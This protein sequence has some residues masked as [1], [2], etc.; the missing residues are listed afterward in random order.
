MAT[1]QKRQTKDGTRYRVQVRLRGHPPVS[2]SFERRTDA[3]K[4]EQDTEAAIR[5]GR[6]FPTHE[7]KRRTLADL[8][9]RQLEA[10]K[11][12]R[13]HDYDR[14]RLLLGWWKKKLGDYTL[15]QCTPALIAEYRDRLLRENTGTKEAPRHRSPATANRFLS[16]L[17]KAFS[18]AVREWHWLHDNPLRRVAKEQ[19][20]QGRVRYLSDDEREKLLNACRKSELTELH[21]I[22]MLALTTGM[23]RGEIL[24]LRWP[25]VDLERRVIV[26]NKT[27]NHD[28]RSVPIVP[29]V[30]DLLG[31][32]G[33][34]RRLDNDMVFPSKPKKQKRRPAPNVPAVVE[35]PHEQG[36]AQQLDNDAVSPRDGHGSL[37]FDDYWYAALDAAKVTDFRFH[38]LRHTAAS[39]LAMSGA[40]VPEIAAVLGHRT[41]Q[42]VKRYAH[43]SDQ[44][45]GQVL[46]RMAEKYFK[47]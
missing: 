7:A 19:E 12:K 18:D 42:M 37:W 9:D 39:Y 34:V 41:L 35:L 24:G 26:L 5:D 47:A 1:I 25:D 46:A 16:A 2:A 13:P 32:H 8:V 4:W 22:V 43:L 14:Q 31:E 23:R 6:Y 28:R 21:L 3:N 38:D 30:L 15:D 29:A 44:H 36:K 27:K 45:T 17:S 10:I 11:S 40:T 20:S 33:K